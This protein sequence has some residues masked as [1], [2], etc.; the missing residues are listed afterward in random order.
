MKNKALFLLL[1][2]GLIFG[3]TN[4][5]TV[6]EPIE[7][8]TKKDTL[9]LGL[10]PPTSKS[11]LFAPG[12][13][14]TNSLEINAAFSPTL[15]EFYFTRQK[16]GETPQIVG[17]QFRNG[18]WEEY[19]EMPYSG[20]PFL[21]ADGQKMYLANVYREQTDSGWSEEKSMGEMFA[22]YEIMR[23]TASTNNTFFFDERDTIGTIWYS[24]LKEG[25]RQPPV[26]LAEYINKGTYTAHPFIAQDESY[27]IWDSNREGGFGDSD[28][29]ISFKQEDGSW[30]EAINMGAEINSDMEDA[31][32]SVTP[33]GKYFLFHRVKMGET[34]EDWDA[35]IYWIDAQIIEELRM[36][37]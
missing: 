29:Y 10:I 19:L 33:D 4:P 27:L 7:P 16:K 32:G 15:D 11:V 14:S 20:E 34:F 25:I 26:A 37:E 31:F 12:I 24:E 3:C 6:K 30:G 9:Y 28:L 36:K 21:S 1:S 18:V 22:P 35:N 5:E 17:I 2:A 13:V 23:L 8:E